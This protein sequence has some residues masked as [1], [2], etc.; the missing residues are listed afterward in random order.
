MAAYDAFWQR[1]EDQLRAQV[2][3]RVNLPVRLSRRRAAVAEAQARAAQRDAE[4][5]RL[6]DQTNFQ[7][8]EA[9]QQVRESERTVRLYDETILPAAE[10]NVRAARAEYAT[11]KVPFVSLIGAQREQ[12]SLRDR[13]FEAVAETIRRRAALHRAVG[14]PLPAP[15]R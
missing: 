7:V 6:T 5:A 4:L 15:V 1:P 11:G 10:Q 8:E 9:Y 3:V 12:V 14:G 2:G 13:Y